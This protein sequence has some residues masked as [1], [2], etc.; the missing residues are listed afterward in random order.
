MGDALPKF[1]C[2]VPILSGGAEATG[3]GDRL[4][5]VAL[6]PRIGNTSCAAGSVFHWRPFGHLRRGCNADGLHLGEQGA[7]GLVKMEMADVP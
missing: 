5:M 6:L 2:R 1:V 4:R 7:G 3:E